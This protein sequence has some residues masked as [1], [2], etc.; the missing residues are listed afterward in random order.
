MHSLRSQERCLWMVWSSAGRRRRPQFLPPHIPARCIMIVHLLLRADRAMLQVPFRPS[1]PRPAP[2]EPPAPSAC[3][4]HTLAPAAVRASRRSARSAALPFPQIHARPYILGRSCP[5]EAGGQVWQRTSCG[6]PCCLP[7]PFNALPSLHN[8][9]SS[10]KAASALL[11]IACRR[12][13]AW[14]LCEIALF[15]LLVILTLWM[16]IHPSSFQ[17]LLEGRRGSDDRASEGGLAPFPQAC[18]MIRR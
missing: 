14:C 13:P 3:A 15:V 2:A 18:G 10:A 9:G 4:P 5:D 8:S 1:L 17:W 12:R 11:G 6:N 16:R 7:F